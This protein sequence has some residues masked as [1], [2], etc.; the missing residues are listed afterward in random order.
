MNRGFCSF[1]L[2]FAWMICAPAQNYP[3]NTTP[4]TFPQTEQTAPDHTAQSSEKLT[5][6]EV[7][8]LIQQGLRSEPTLVNTKVIAKAND[9]SVVLTGKVH[10]EKQHSMAL[11]IAKSHAGEREIIDHITVAGSE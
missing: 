6:P 5:P 4:P 1:L 9:A 7:E 8:K 2:V 10:D 3:P 11:L